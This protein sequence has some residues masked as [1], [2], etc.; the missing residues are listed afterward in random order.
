MD[1]TFCQSRCIVGHPTHSCSVNKIL[2]TNRMENTMRKLRF[3]AFQRYIL[4][5]GQHLVEV[6]QNEAFLQIYASKTAFL[7]ITIPDQLT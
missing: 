3:I 4:K 5:G 7:S 2:T 1:L 6:S